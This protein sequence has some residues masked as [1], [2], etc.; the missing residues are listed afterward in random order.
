MIPSRILTAILV[1]V[2]S[3]GSALAGSFEARGS[4]RQFFVIGAAPGA[5]VE[6]LDSKGLVVQEGS[7]DPLGGLLFR[8]VEPGDGYFA[9]VTVKGKTTFSE[10]TRVLS[11]KDVPP[12]SFYESQVLPLGIYGQAGY[13]YLTTRDGTQLS[14]QVQ[15][16][17]FGDGI[18]AEAYPTVIEYSGYDPSNPAPDDLLGGRINEFRL[19][20]ALLGYAYVGVNIRGTGCSGGA[21]DYFEPLQSI[22]GYDIVEVV[23]AQAWVQNGRPGMVGISYSGISQ[24][25]VAQTRPP[26]LA[27][28]TPLSVIDDTFRGTLYPG[29]IFNDG[30]ARS[31]AIERQ[32]QNRWPDPVGADWVVNRVNEGDAICADDQLLRQQNPDLLAKIERNPFYPAVG[33]PEYPDGGDVLA[34]F[35]FVRQINVPTFMVGAWQDDQTGGHWSVM[36]DQFDSATELRVVANNGTHADS[37]GPVNLL[38]L[39]EFLDFRVGGRLPLVPLEIRGLAPLLYSLIFAADGV[40]LPPDRFAEYT[41][42]QALAIYDRENRFHIS[43]ESGAKPGAHTLGSPE[44]AAESSYAQWPPAE[45]V[46]QRLYLQPEGGLTADPPT[47]ADDDPLASHAYL[48]DPSAKPRTDFRCPGGGDPNTCRS[49]IWKAGAI[50]DWRPLPVDYTL[51]FLSEPLQEQLTLLGSASADLWIASTEPDTDIEITLTEVRPDGQERYV[52]NGWLR[53]SHRRLDEKRSTELRPRQTHL[54]ADAEPLP[55]SDFAFVRVEIFPFAHVFRPGS[56]LRLNVE[57]PGGNRPLWT[58]DA[59]GGKD[60]T[61]WVAHSVH[62]PSSVALPVVSDIEVPAELPPC[63]TSLRAQPCRPYR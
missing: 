35:A 17:I 22:D 9:A 50:Y 62:R 24:L 57:A 10:P 1:L 51:S 30:F 40:E 39:M 26:H 18:A 55:K 28:I 12:Q 7:T 19:L 23:A 25:F 43:W 44:P 21:F 52:Q 16:P 37:L 27:A 49:E 4:L 11:E 46:A 34:P 42:E 38:R 58:F 60:V 5:S 61:N 45:T 53:A 63:P 56:R 47:I 59:L 29:G 32:Q 3:G 6:L 33:N 20:A 48:Y 8:N 14:V 13:G 41:Y 36:L 54:E 15:L 2:A 31:W